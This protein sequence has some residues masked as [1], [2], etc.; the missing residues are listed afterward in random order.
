MNPVLRFFM[1]PLKYFARSQIDFADLP[2]YLATQD[3]NGGVSMN[4]NAKV[5]TP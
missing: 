4:Q 1:E 2:V 3:K 5:E